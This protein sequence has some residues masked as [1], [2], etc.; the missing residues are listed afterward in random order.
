MKDRLFRDNP[1][2]PDYHTGQNPKHRLIP[3][4]TADLP[5]VHEVI[6]DLR[7]VVDEFE[8][9]V[10]IGEIYLPLEKLVTYYGR[11][12]RGCHLPFNFSLLLVEWRARVIAELVE[13]YEKLLPA[14]GWPNWVLGNHDRPRVASRI[15]RAQARIAAMLLLSL[16]GTPTIYY[17]DEIGMVQVPIPPEQARDPLEKNIPGLGL[18][19]DGARTPMQWDPSAHAGFST[20]NPWLPVAAD[21][22][23]ENVEN[24]RRDSTSIYHLYRRLIAARRSH[25]ALSVGSYHP[26]S[27]RGDLV[28]YTRE[29]EGDRVLIAL[30][31][32]ADPISVSFPQPLQGRVLVSCFGDRDDESVDGGIELRP[33]EGLF[34]ALAA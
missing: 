30:N 12:L 26:I 13:Q 28:L 14:G 9:R 17:G 27:A 33:H 2:N 20:A 7:G 3:F 24:A 18:G 23:A 15:G 10:L 29:H 21:F 5:E 11:D 1:V 32:G 4:Y 19:R 6:A 16:R 25:P 34:V 31:L 8:D 22:R